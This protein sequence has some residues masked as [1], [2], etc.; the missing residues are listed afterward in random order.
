MSTNPFHPGAVSFISPHNPQFISAKVHASNIESDKTVSVKNTDRLDFTNITSNELTQT[1]F[2]LYKEGKVERK[3]MQNMIFLALQTNVDIKSLTKKG[4]VAYKRYF[5]VQADTKKNYF[6]IAQ[7]KYEKAKEMNDE[8]G[9]KKMEETILLL[10]ALQNSIL[11]TD[12][13]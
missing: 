6:H 8:V 1:A 4:S 10:S 2:T 3:E 5:E 9:A 13:S 7:S 11:G 12:D